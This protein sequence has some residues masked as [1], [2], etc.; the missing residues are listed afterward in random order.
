MLL[1]EM[2]FGGYLLW[3]LFI[4][5]VVIGQVCKKASPAVKSAVAEG[6]TR[7]AVGFIGK[8]LK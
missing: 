7:K 8:L 2:S 5:A 4:L 1:A 6:A 3:G